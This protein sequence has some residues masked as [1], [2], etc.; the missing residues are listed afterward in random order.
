MVLISSNQRCADEKAS[1]PLGLS[2]SGPAGRVAWKPRESFHIS[3]TLTG[4]CP[5]NP[6]PAPFVF[7]SS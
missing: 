3:L 4:F 2:P 6:C 7:G 5:G 1:V